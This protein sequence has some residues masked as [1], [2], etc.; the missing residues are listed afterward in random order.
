MGA[1]VQIVLQEYNDESLP[2]FGCITNN[3]TQP[4]W[5]QLARHY[6]PIDSQASACKIITKLLKTGLEK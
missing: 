5:S 2:N 3:A 6:V 1:P 4:Q